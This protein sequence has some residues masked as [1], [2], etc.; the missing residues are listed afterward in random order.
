MTTYDLTT[1]AEYP[2]LDHRIMYLTGCSTSHT[3]QLHRA[4]VGLL[5]TPDSSTHTQRGNY[6]YWAAD[7]GC[8]AEFASGRPFDAARWLR[9]LR[10]IDPADCL[11]AV[12]P[13][14]VGDAAATWRRS[15]PYVE[16]VKELG[17]PVAVVLQDGIEAEPVVWAEMM[18]AAD[19]V[20]I[21]GSTDFKLGDVA[22]AHV[23]EAREVGMW[24][25]MGR[26]NSLKRLR[27]AADFGCD[28]AD[29]TY[30]G[31][32]PAKNTLRLCGWLDVI[33]GGR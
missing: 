19:A 9:W 26:V 27:I 2:Q 33:N 28:S 17:Y 6:H 18:S 29:G 15:A 30:V 8:F 10:A 25:H 22:R 16:V 32:S 4:D 23:A 13:D 31:F 1:R 14:V 11:F 24:S 12:L 20:F 21:G 7:N 3:R 5:A